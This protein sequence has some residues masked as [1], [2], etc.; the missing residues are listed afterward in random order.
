MFP[1]SVAPEIQFWR[2][3]A[4]QHAHTGSGVTID[5]AA[6]FGICICLFL[7]AC[8][9]AHQTQSRCSECDAWPVRCRC[10]QDEVSRRG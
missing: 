2:E 8:W 7:L 5:P 9:A 1:E 4:R 10:G 6:L 3:Y